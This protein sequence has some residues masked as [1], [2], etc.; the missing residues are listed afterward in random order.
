[1]KAKTGWRTA[2]CRDFRCARRRIANIIEPSQKDFESL[3]P[4][5]PN[6]KYIWDSWFAWNGDELHAFYLQACKAE[7]GYN[8]DERHNRSSVGHAVLSPWG[9]KELNGAPALAAA[10]G[11]TWDN[12][13]IWTGSIVQA[14]PGGPY[15]LFYT[16]RRREDAPLWTPSEWQR[17]QQIGLAVSE[18]LHD[19]KRAGKHPVIPNF[20]KPLGLDGVAWR[21]PYLMRG[22]N[23]EW[24]AFVC[25]RLNPHDRNHSHI[26]LDAGGA[27]VWLRSQKLDEWRVEETRMLVTSTEFYQMEVPQTFWREFADGK[28]FYL[29]FC[30]QEKDC[31]QSRRNRKLACATGTYYL[32]SDLLP[33]AYADIPPLREPAELLAP[34]LYAGKLLRPEGDERP[35]LLG[36]PFADAAGH[37]AGGISDPLQAQFH[38]DGSIT[39]NHG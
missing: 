7:C 35:V 22:A 33:F 18:D 34:N 2:P 9:W 29:L 26:G 8:P 14:E 1:V 32:R 5:S 36:F 39:L 37:F 3:M 6:N 19:W 4:W 30:A 20:G 23:G 10:D 27:I 38:N 16:A 28:R 24:Y 11:G 12:L 31:S 17:P 13:A 15:H 21:D 25:A